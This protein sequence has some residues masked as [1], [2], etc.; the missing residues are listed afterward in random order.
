MGVE[1]EVCE[2]FEDAQLGIQAA[3]TAGM[4]ATLV[5]DFYDVTIGQEI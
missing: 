1:P 5:T 2:V 3:K 4:M